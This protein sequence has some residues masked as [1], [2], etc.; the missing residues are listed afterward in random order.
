MTTPAEEGEPSAM[1]EA[2]VRPRVTVIIPVRTNDA[3]V[4]EIVAA[5]GTELD[6]LG[7]SWECILVFDGVRGAAWDAGLALQASSANQVRTIA[8]NKAFGE[9]VCLASAFEH[10]AGECILTATQYVQIDPR[11]L[12]RLF[13]AYDGGA[14]FVT[15][16][17]WPRIDSWL[18]RVQSAGFNWVMRRIVGTKFHDLNCT[19]RVIRRSVLE[20][21]T[22][23]GD[24]YRYLPAIAFQQGFRVEEVKV[25]H[26][27]ELGGRG[28]Y[29]PGVYARRLLDILGVMFL[30]KFTHKPLRFF[31]SLG[32]LLAAIGALVSSVS[33]VQR[34]M[35]SNV[36]LFERPMFLLGV[37]VFV[38]GVQ[39]IGF[40]LVGEIIIFTQARNVREYSVERTYE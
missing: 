1:D 22:I 14:D 2:A 15:P 11:E 33:L 34:L 4:A 23:Y 38:L 10:A 31:G 8:L 24:M 20:D 36:G 18:N 32:G 37:V 16:W 12:E 27:S 6:R 25:R 35:N 9:S 26:I 30:T 21:L 3:R 13:A 29:G 17:R 19:W 5:I 39:I 7:R 40:G 28:I